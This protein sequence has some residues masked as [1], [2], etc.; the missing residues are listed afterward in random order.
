MLERIPRRAPAFAF[1]DPEGSELHWSTVEA[2]ADHKC[3]HAKTKI[4][5]LI[6][7]PVDMGFVRRFGTQLWILWLGAGDA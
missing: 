2:I 3:G 1:L 7:F 4:E 6:L 5:Q